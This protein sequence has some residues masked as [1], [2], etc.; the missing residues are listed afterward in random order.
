MSRVDVGAFLVDYS[1]VDV[2]W[3]VGQRMDQSRLSIV[4]NAGTLVFGTDGWCID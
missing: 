1:G 2:G 4:S 3:Y